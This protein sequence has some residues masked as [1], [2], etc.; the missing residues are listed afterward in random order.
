MRGGVGVGTVSATLH[1]H[2]HDGVA[3]AKYEVHR[4][5]H[6]KPVNS[7]VILS[8]TLQISS[9]PTIF[10]RPVCSLYMTC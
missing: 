4:N 6:V 3:S 1:L 7:A 8:D 10:Y 9:C 2:S 5:S